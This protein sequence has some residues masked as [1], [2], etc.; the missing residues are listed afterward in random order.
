MKCNKLL[1]SNATLYHQYA[2]FI[3]NGA[4]H[5]D[6]ITKALKYPSEIVQKL[7][8][9]KAGTILDDET[10]IQLVSDTNLPIRVRLRLI[11]SV[12]TKN[13]KV[14]LKL[15]PIVAKEFGNDSAALLLP[16]S[17]E[18]DEQIV[19]H[20]LDANIRSIKYISAWVRLRPYAVLLFV[21]RLYKKLVQGNDDIDFHYASAYYAVQWNQTILVSLLRTQSN[22]IVTALLNLLDEILLEPY[23]KKNIQAFQDSFKHSLLLY[24][25]DN[26]LSYFARKSPSRL[27]QFMIDTC[28][29][30]GI[31][32]C[33]MIR[34]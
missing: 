15:F 7:A 27:T 18:T 23:R 20:L 33:N 34:S 32:E 6:V 3:A 14:L 12:R 19:Q 29:S 5:K 4:N 28:N 11:K 21:K 10:I 30:F 25:G 1:A 9:Y 26:T 2:I 31:G 22:E 8:A 16:F 13:K 24:Y 17:Q